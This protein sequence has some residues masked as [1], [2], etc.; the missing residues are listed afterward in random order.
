MVL[1]GQQRERQRELFGESLVGG[2]RI[3]ADTKNDGLTGV[4]G[5]Q[6]VAETA[7]FPGS[8]GGIV[9]WIKVEQHVLFPPELAQPNRTVRKGGE[10][11]SGSPVTGLGHLCLGHAWI[12]PCRRIGSFTSGDCERRHA[13]HPRHGL[14][15]ST[16]LNRTIHCVWPVFLA[17]GT[18]VARPTCGR[19]P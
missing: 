2:Q 5:G 10:T 4:E 16:V 15:V 7:G 11:E 12:V 8:A 19:V 6:L 3:G 1:I 9:T 13:I 18:R 17:F 14:Q